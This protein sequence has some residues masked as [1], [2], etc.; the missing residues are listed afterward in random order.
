MDGTLLNLYYYAG[1]W[2]V[3]TLGAIDAGGTP[4]GSSVTYRELFWQWFKRLNL[5]VPTEAGQG[6]TWMFELVCPETHV[7]V[8]HPLDGLYFLGARCNDSGTELFPDEVID[9][10]G[11]KYPCVNEVRDKTCLSEVKAAFLETSGQTVEG[12]VVVDSQF[13]RLKVKHPM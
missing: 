10:A 1:Q 2:R 8:K 12:F 4:K 7:V 6:Y 3:A 5:A 13:R 11:V 9:I